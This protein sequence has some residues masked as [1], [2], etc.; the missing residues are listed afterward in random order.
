L[1]QFG[2]D[3][4]YS[5]GALLVQGK[6]ILLV[7][8]LNPA[9]DV[10]QTVSILSLVEKVTVPVF[11]ET[12][13]ALRASAVKSGNMSYGD[14]IATGSVHFSDRH[15]L[16]PYLNAVTKCDKNGQVRVGVMNTTAE[17]IVIPMGTKYGSFSRII[18][19]AHHSSFS[20]IINIAH[21][22]E[23]PF[24]V[25]VI[26]GANVLHHLNQDEHDG[27]GKKKKMTA[28]KKTAQELTK[29]DQSWYTGWL[30]QLQ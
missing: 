10:E 21:H 7:A 15:D 3:Q 1:A 16:H 11:S 20:R 30:G 9:V 12:K 23:H 28:K 27:P 18:D 29:L 4:L 26:N 25:A 24:H 13:F 6:K 2:I 19:I 5:E 8:L 14:G 22:S 17:A